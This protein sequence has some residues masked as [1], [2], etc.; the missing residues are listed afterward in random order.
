MY[1]KVVWQRK[2]R[3]SNAQE[4]GEHRR[5]SFGDF[6]LILSACMCVLIG[7]LCVLDYIFVILITNFC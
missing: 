3:V 5:R 4:G 7:F 6:V 1:L 2:I